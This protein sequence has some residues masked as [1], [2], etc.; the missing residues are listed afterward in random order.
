LPKWPIS[1]RCTARQYLKGLV[2]NAT[3]QL[4]R[5]RQHVPSWRSRHNPEAIAAPTVGQQH[6]GGKPRRHDWSDLDNARKGL[7]SCPEG[8]V[9]PVDDWDPVEEHNQELVEV[10]LDGE[11]EQAWTLVQACYYWG[12]NSTEAATLV[13][14]GIHTTAL[15]QLDSFR[16]RARAKLEVYPLSPG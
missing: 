4:H 5:F 7:P 2:R 8:I 11:P 13:G 1:L 14:V 6:A 9:D 3:K 16:L 15:R 12:M 10:A